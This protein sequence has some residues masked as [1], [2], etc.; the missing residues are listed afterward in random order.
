MTVE[1]SCDNCAYCG[2]EP[3]DPDPVC[4][5]PVVTSEHVFG[6]YVDRAVTKFCG[7]GR[8]L[9][10]AYS[11]R[12][13]GKTM[14]FIEYLERQIRF[15][16]ETFGPGSRTDGVI[17]HIKKELV[18]VQSA[19]SEGELDNAAKEWV[20]V[21]LL[22]LD[23]LWRSISHKNDD[24]RDWGNDDHFVASVALT[25]A[26]MI[27]DKLSIN[28]DRNWPDWRTADAGKAIEHVRPS[29]VCSNCQSIL[30]M[31]PQHI[32]GMRCKECGALSA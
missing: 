11:L 12:L 9:F 27:D 13:E 5:H 4:N 2:I 30:P 28:E 20:D 14:N 26:T 22:G 32:A 21:V 6:L 1:R 3:S 17:D 23:G 10:L 31:L 24:G 25:A 16:R 19:F 7:Q 29:N 8:S 18:E 15:S